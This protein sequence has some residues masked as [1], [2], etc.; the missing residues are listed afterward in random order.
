MKHLSHLSVCI[1][2]SQWTKCLELSR[3]RH[4]WHHGSYIPNMPDVQIF[5][6]FTHYKEVHQTTI[7]ERYSGWINPPGLARRSETRIWYSLYS[8]CILPRGGK[9]LPVDL[10][11]EPNIISCE[12]AMLWFKCPI[13]DSESEGSN[14]FYQLFCLLLLFFIFQF[15]QK[16]QMAFV[17]RKNTICSQ[18]AFAMEMRSNS[19]RR[20]LDNN[21]VQNGH[22][23]RWVRLRSL[24][25]GLVHLLSIPWT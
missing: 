11:N 18:P 19:S 24:C 7:S 12:T 17:V 6:S 9:T 22:L 3:N 2:P 21:C 14:P 23:D 5:T 16:E 25:P 13:H 8:I 10:F 4:L 1:E 15:H 20:T